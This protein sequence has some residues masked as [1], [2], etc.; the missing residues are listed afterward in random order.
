MYFGASSFTKHYPKGTLDFEVSW[1]RVTEGSSWALQLDFGTVP[2]T[3]AS[4]TTRKTDSTSTATSIQSS[5]STLGT[6]NDLSTTTKSGRN[7]M[8]VGS[9]F[10]VFLMTMM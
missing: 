9:F 8:A 10:V 2:D 7:M 3:V 6:S 4:S 1:T 5:M